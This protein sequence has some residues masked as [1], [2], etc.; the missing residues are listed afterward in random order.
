MTPSNIKIKN[1]EIR[2]IK[3]P[4]PENGTTKKQQGKVIPGYI[5]Y[6]M[7]TGKSLEVV[8]I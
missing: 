6:M 4:R 7:I 3:I 2:M 8:K 5:I 1:K